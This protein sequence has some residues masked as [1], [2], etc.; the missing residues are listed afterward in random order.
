MRVRVFVTRVSLLYCI[1]CLYCIVSTVFIKD[2]WFGLRNSISSLKLH[3]N[4]VYKCF[5]GN[6]SIAL[7]RF[8]AEFKQ[9]HRLPILSIVLSSE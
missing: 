1:N 3:G 8:L 7:M 9:T 4:I 5:L 6:G 2:L